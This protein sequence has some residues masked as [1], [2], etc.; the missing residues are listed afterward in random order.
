MQVAILNGVDT[1]GLHEEV[2]ES[3]DLKEVREVVMLSI[4]RVFQAGGMANAKA[5]GWSMTGVLEGEQDQGTRVEL[6]ERKAVAV[7]RQHRGGSMSFRAHR[8]RG[9]LRFWSRI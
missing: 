9:S 3:N 8:M 2:T 1:A 4:G 6:G 5:L 7:F